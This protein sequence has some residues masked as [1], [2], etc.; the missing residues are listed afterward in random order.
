[1]KAIIPDP[2]VQFSRRFSLESIIEEISKIAFDVYINKND[3][4]GSL[5][6]YRDYYRVVNGKPIKQSVMIVQTWLIDLIYDVVIDG[7]HTNRTITNN[8]ALQLIALYSE[9]CD[10]LDG[11][12]IKNH[13]DAILNLYGFFGEQKRFEEYEFVN[14]YSR[15]SYILEDISVKEHAKNTYG[16]DFCEEFKEI[17]GLFPDVYSTILFVLFGYFAT[18]SP[19]ISIS[20][21]ECEFSN[22]YL[23]VE[24]FIKLIDN[25]T[26]TLDELSSSKFGRQTLYLKPFVKIDDKYISINPFLVLCLF[27]NANYWIIRNKY[28]QDHDDKQKFVN[29]FGVYFEIYVEEILSNCLLSTEFTNISETSRKRADWHLKLDKYDFLI[30]QKSTLSMLSIKQNRPN[31]DEFKNYIKKTWGEA[32]EQLYET[33]RDLSLSNA[34]K[35]ILIYEDYYMCESLD[36][37]FEL[38]PDLSDKNDKK[39]WLMTVRE[40]EMLMHTYKTDPKKFLSIV[41]QKDDAELTNSKDGRSLL[42][43]LQKEKIK[44]NSY[45]DE[46]GILKKY[47]RIIDVANSKQ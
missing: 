19:I 18:N 46:A 44:T 25:Y 28:L 11:K 8:D 39:Y 34:I 22:P 31:V 29:A 16:I 27:T 40:F 13:Q 3:D 45:L 6:G 41:K 17:T 38:R 35:I 10:N 24:N 21:M 26:C 47:K 23:N 36:L 14:D 33:E 2:F 32:V 15:E 1:M 20:K 5:A 4:F 9:Y 43:F 30:E 12:R 7:K 37:L 42:K